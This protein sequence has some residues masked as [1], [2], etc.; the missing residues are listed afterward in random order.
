[1]CYRLV[2]AFV[3]SAISWGARVQ[4]KLTTVQSSDTQEKITT[5]QSSDTEGNLTGANKFH[6]TPT[7]NHAWCVNRAH[8]DVVVMYACNHP[9]KVN[10]DWIYEHE[11]LKLNGGLCLNLAY[12]NIAQGARVDV[13]PCNNHASQKW[14]WSGDKIKLKANPQWCLTNSWNKMQNYNPILLGKC[15]GDSSQKWARSPLF[16]KDVSVCLSAIYEGENCCGN[17]EKCRN[18]NCGQTTLSGMEGNKWS[19]QDSKQHSTEISTEVS[20][21][22][23]AKMGSFS[24]AVKGTVASASQSFRSSSGEMKQGYRHVIMYN[25]DTYLYQVIV[26]TRLLDGTTIQT[27]GVVSKFNSKQKGPSC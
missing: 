7:F 4:Q 17:N 14:I 20:A 10:Q 6:I 22:I 2:L 15:S 11:N 23:S 26:T 3:L 5:E 27:K 21:A 1:M 19:K 24:S 9:Y 12:M 18:V 16:V 8:G 25:Q 13:Y